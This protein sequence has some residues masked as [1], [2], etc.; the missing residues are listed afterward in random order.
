[1]TLGLMRFAY[2]VLERRRFTSIYA[3]Y[4]LM[5]A[6]GG[7]QLLAVILRGDGDRLHPSPAE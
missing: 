3:C 7:V 6:S 5:S 4:P 2:S 1:M